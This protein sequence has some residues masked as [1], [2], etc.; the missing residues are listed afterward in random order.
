MDTWNN[1]EGSEDDCEE[2]HTYM[3]LMDNLE[4]SDSIS[5]SDSDS[6]EVFSNLTRSEVKSCLTEILEKFQSLQNRHKD[7][8]RIHV[9]ECEA[10]NELKKENSNMK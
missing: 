2:E 9:A 1:S 3:A 8:K 10:L 7:L 5:E 4:A 6:N